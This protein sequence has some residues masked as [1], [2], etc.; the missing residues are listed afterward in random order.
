M[1]WKIIWH[2]KAAKNLDAL[3]KDIRDRVIKRVDKL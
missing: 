1:S 2:P 3:P